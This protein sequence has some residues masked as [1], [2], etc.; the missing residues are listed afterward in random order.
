MDIIGQTCFKLSRK[1]ACWCWHE[2]KE[3]VIRPI[4]PAKIA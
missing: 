3:E 4:L 2:P 1:G